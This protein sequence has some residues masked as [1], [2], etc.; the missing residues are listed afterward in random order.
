[1]PDDTNKC[2]PLGIRVGLKRNATQKIEFGLTKGCKKEDDRVEA[3]WTIHFALLEKDGDEFTAKVSVDIEI[4]KEAPGKEKQAEDTANDGLSHL[5]TLYLVGPVARSADAVIEQPNVDALLS[6]FDPASF[7]EASKDEQLF[8]ELDRAADAH[9][10]NVRK[11]RRRVVGV[12]S[13]P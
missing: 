9:S 2:T 10:E 3:T 5:Q 4:N 7:N 8:A 12:L 11:L 1:M 13:L 6:N